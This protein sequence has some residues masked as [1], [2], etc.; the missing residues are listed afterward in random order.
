[1][2]GT[3]YRSQEWAIALRAA[4]GQARRCSSRTPALEEQSGALF[5]GWRSPYSTAASGVRRKGGSSCQP[6]QRRRPCAASHL[7]L[8]LGDA[9]RGREGYSGAGGTSGPVHHAAIHARQSSRSRERNS[10]AR[11]PCSTHGPGRRWGG[12]IRRSLKTS[13][14]KGEGWLRGRDLNPRP[15][16]YEPNELPDC[17]TPRQE[18]L[19][20][21][22]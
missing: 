4:H 12:G 11:L 3:R 2:E 18:N 5:C 6:S 22:H 10:A 13:I 8:A 16:G 7:L 15:L 1:M 20:V 17:S 14:S 21:A 9:R 19:I